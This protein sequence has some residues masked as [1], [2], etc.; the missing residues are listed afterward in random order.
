MTKPGRPAEDAEGGK[1]SKP[2]ADVPPSDPKSEA[3][4]AES[5]GG[6]DVGDRKGG[7]DG[8]KR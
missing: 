4:G 8:A 6:A 7:R 1:E 3:K 2:G 5:S